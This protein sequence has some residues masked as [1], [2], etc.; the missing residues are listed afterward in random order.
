[1]IASRFGTFRRAI[2]V[3]LITAVAAGDLLEA[4]STLENSAS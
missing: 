4:A 3:A 1:M 2:A